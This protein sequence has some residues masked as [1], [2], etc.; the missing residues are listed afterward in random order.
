MTPC[1]FIAA[2]LLFKRKQQEPLLFKAVSSPTVC[3][4]SNQPT[5]TIQIVT[6]RTPKPTCFF[7]AS[8]A[9]RLLLSFLRHRSTNRCM[10][11]DLARSVLNNLFF[12]VW[13]S[14]RMKLP[15]WGQRRCWRTVVVG[16]RKALN[17]WSEPSHEI[18]RNNISSVRTHEPLLLRVG[19][20]VIWALSNNLTAS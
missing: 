12:K 19:D 17:N 10:L 6:Q 2:R 9:R 20:Y 1:V 7:T 16:P 15:C 18:S 4:A 5:G 11:H 14:P 13:R 8:L 3:V